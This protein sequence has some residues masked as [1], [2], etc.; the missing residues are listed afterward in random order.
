MTPSSQQIVYTVLD[1]LAIIPPTLL[2]VYAVLGIFTGRVARATATPPWCIL[3]VASV[4]W[5]ALRGFGVVA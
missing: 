4:V 1:C 2:T 3:W 5:L